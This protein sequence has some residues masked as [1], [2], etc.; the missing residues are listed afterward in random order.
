MIPVTPTGPGAGLRTLALLLR[1]KTPLH[2]ALIQTADFFSGRG[3]RAA[4]KRVA[5]SVAKGTSYADAF[6]QESDRFPP[7]YAEIIVQALDSGDAASVLTALASHHD[8]QSAY[9]REFYQSIIPLIT[10]LAGTVVFGI[11]WSFHIV[12]L[13][14]E[15][16]FHMGMDAP[17]FLHPLSSLIWI[18]PAVFVFM[19]ILLMHS[20]GTFIRKGSVRNIM[21]L[22]IWLRTMGICLNTKMPLHQALKVSGSP[23]NADTRSMDGESLGTILEAFPRIP[24]SLAAV[25]GTAEKHG[26]LQS[27]CERYGRLYYRFAMIRMKFTI[28]RLVPILLIICALIGGC[29]VFAGYMVYFNTLGDAAEALKVW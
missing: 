18:I 3:D 26:T 25:L 5:A 2:Q 17:T 8:L 10:V 22:A 24:G 19:V 12:P 29:A 15:S 14:R 6:R 1:R 9:R 27:V 28:S 20:S 21:D 4:W 11:I 13:F 16:Y 7:G 23:E